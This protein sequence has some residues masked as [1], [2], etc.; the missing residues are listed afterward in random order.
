MTVWG[1][2][3]SLY[4]RIIEETRNLMPQQSVY[5]VDMSIAFKLLCDEVDKLQECMGCH[6]KFKHQE[7]SDPLVEDH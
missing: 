1:L 3:M 7:E 4:N 2:M 6:T 5:G